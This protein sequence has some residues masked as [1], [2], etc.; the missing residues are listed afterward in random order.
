MLLSIWQ[1]FSDNLGGM[2]KVGRAI[3]ILGNEMAREGKDD[4][5]SGRDEMAT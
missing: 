1:H 3:T 2:I 5:A 4:M